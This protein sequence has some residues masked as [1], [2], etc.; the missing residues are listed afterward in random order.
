MKEFTLSFGKIFILQDDIAEIIVDDMIEMD[1]VMVEEYHE[2][3]LSHLTP[4]FS[5]LINKKNSYTYTFEAQLELANLPE[6]NF[7]AVVAYN[8]FTQSTTKDLIEM[9]R[10]T[11]W[12]IQIFAN[13]ASA[14]N[15]LEDKQ[16]SVLL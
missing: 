7:M 4:P 3:L 11:P 10:D 9:P 5:L 6:I 2:F 1:L 12:N 8:Y 16:Q 14:L 13:R 15:W